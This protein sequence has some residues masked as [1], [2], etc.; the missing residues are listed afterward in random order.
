MPSTNVE[1]VGKLR[2]RSIA[3]GQTEARRRSSTAW[4]F[5]CLLGGAVARA[6]LFDGIEQEGPIRAAARVAVILPN[7]DSGVQLRACAA[8]IR[9]WCQAHVI[10]EISTSELGQ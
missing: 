10:D 9:A 6:I 8:N 1:W 2:C 3:W 5:V 7:K 4:F